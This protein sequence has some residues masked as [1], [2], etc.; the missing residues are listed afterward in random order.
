MNNT[1]AAAQCEWTL[2]WLHPPG[3]APRSREP[4]CA[5]D[6]S[7][8]FSIAGW[9]RGPVVEA[10]LAEPRSRL[11]K[12]YLRALQLDVRRGPQQCINDGASPSRVRTSVQW[13]VRR[14]QV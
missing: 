3:I 2:S 6:L 9:P 11:L 5:C 13:Y 10:R 1:D 8:D 12:K 7:R 4:R 14:E